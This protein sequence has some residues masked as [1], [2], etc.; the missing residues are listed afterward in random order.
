[1]FRTQ[2][3]VFSSKLAIFRIE[4]NAIKWPS[5]GVAVKTRMID[6]VTIIHLI[7]SAL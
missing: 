2:I 4:A 5:F 6:D 3:P 1:M 7:P